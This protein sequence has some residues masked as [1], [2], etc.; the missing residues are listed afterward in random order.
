MSQVRLVFVYARWETMNLEYNPETKVLK[1]DNLV[2]P[3]FEPEKEGSS[4]W[5]KP[6]GTIRML[7]FEEGLF[8]EIKNQK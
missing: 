2:E 5:R 1:F 6:D 3:I 8:A 7:K 4:D